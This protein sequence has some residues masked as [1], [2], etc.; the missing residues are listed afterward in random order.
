[1]YLNEEDSTLLLFLY[2]NQKY[3]IVHLCTYCNSNTEHVLRRTGTTCASGLETEKYAVLQQ[4]NVCSQ[5]DLRGSPQISWRAAR[6]AVVGH[7]LRIR[8]R[9]PDPCRTVSG[10]DSKHVLHACQPMFALELSLYKYMYS[11]QHHSDN[12]STAKNLN[13]DAPILYVC[14]MSTHVQYDIQSKQDD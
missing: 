4:C 8:D 7:W 1:M 2:L 13:A 3:M 11:N 10:K 9:P 6:Q 12:N 5:T 14:T